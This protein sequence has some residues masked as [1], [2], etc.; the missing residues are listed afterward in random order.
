MIQNMDGIFNCMTHRVLVFPVV[1]VFWH[2]R[3]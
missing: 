3:K 2:V 1:V